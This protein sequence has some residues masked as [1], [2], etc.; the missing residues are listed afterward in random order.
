M[1][2]SFF[3]AIP[4]TYAHSMDLSQYSLHVKYFIKPK[5]QLIDN[6]QLTL[7]DPFVFNWQERGIFKNK[8]NNS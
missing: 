6:S 3:K 2:F 4:H 1:H 8:C 5:I 7:P